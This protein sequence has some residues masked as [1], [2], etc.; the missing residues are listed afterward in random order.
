MAATTATHTAMNEEKSESTESVRCGI[1]ITV[2]LY[3]LY[4][5]MKKLDF[6]QL[7]HSLRRP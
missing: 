5:Y 1:I 4:E 6:I 3:E 7:Q 2:E